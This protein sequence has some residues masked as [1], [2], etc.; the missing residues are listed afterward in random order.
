MRSTTTRH[1]QPLNG[2]TVDVEE[3]FQVSAFDDLLS[4][5]SW[6]Q[7]TSRLRD[8]TMRLLDL[9]DES[10]TKATFFVLGWNAERH[11][12]LVRQIADRGHEIASHGYS[13]RLVYTQSE[14]EFRKEAELSRR[15][16]QDAS[17]QPVFGYRAASFS[18]GK[19]SLWALDALV[20]AGFRYDSS[21][22]PIVHDR[23]GIPDASRRIGE[24]NTPQGRRLIEVPPSTVRILATNLPI[25]GGG[26]LRILPLAL[27]RWAFRR[28]IREGLPAIVYLHPWEIDPRQPRVKAPLRTR[29]RHYTGLHTTET[30]LR[31]LAS[32]F[33]F[34]RLQDILGQH[35]F[36][37]WQ[38]ET[39][40][41]E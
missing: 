34:G 11:P 6:G 37:E 36:A 5:N 26:Y 25:G 35:G 16:L 7:Q 9:L 22:F 15:L 40:S 24:L 2:L 29:F 3:H 27:T 28:L 32:S 14:R 30:K 20:D 19:T 21:V 38:D 33:S 31:A 18:I 23:Y 12:S 13:H 41:R 4:R 10:H 39:A 8:N 17:G 1:R